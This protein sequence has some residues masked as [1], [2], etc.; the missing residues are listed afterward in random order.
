[1]GVDDLLEEDASETEEQTTDDVLAEAYKVIEVDGER[2]VF[3]TEDDW[4]SMV[5]SVKDK[6]GKD[7]TGKPKKKQMEVI[8]RA[9]DISVSMSEECSICGEEYHFPDYWELVQIG[10]FFFCKEHNLQEVIKFLEDN[11]RSLHI[12]KQT[13]YA[14]R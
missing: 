2:E 3:K 11:N 4:K 14:S 7:I 6:L 8:K 1:M 12:I 10:G 5:E 9:K 13:T